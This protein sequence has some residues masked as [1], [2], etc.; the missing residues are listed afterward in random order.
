MKNLDDVAACQNLLQVVLETV[1]KG[2]HSQHV[3]HVAVVLE[4]QLQQG[5]RLALDEAFAV[6]T[7]HWVRI[8]HQNLPTEALHELRRLNESIVFVRWRGA[9]VTLSSLTLELRRVAAL[10]SRLRE[11]SSR[12]NKGCLACLWLR[13]GRLWTRWAN[14]RHV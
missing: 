7:K 4:A 13:Y 5:Y 1:I 9:W 14:R 6:Q 12:C 3:K 2:V 11:P 10:H 8:A